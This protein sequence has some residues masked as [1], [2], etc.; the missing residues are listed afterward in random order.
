MASKASSTDNDER[1]AFSFSVN[2]AKKSLSESGAY[3]MEDASAGR[4]VNEFIYTK[5]LPFREVEGLAF[6]AQNS[7]YDKVSYS[8]DRGASHNY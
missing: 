2:D 4:R 6:C 1:A 7:F 8:T 3:V 5:G